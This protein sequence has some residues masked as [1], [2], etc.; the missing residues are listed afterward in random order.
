M[1]SLYVSKTK[2]LAMLAPRPAMK[3][4][5]LG[6]ILRPEMNIVYR[7]TAKGVA[8][9]ETRAHRLLPRL[10]G[11]LILVDGKRSD[12]ELALLIAADPGATLDSLLDDGFIEVLAT[13][14]DRPPAPRQATKAAAVP[15]AASAAGGRSIEALRREAVRYLT[16]Q[17][18]PGAES[19]AIK[20]E[21]AKTMPE[22]QPHLA[23][24]AQVLRDMRGAAAAEAFTAKFISAPEA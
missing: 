22:L 16:D 13:L 2:F 6:A 10:R 18:G 20:I 3:T 14:A 9:I 4:V 19:V 24:G 1:L 17:L 15:A 8:E 21:R 7:K 12:D 11:A 23:L 5:P